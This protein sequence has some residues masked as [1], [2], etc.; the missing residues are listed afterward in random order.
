VWAENKKFETKRGERT[1]FLNFLAAVPHLTKEVRPSLG[2]QKI[3]VCVAELIRRT[4][5]H[6]NIDGCGVRALTLLSTARL[7]E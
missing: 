3:H 7:S 6:E 2:S 5:N 4:P 1:L